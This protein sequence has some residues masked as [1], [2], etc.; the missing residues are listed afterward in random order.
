M[1]LG[2]SYIIIASIS[3]YD[4]YKSRIYLDFRFFFNDN[5]IKPVRNGKEVQIK[6]TRREMS[7]KTIRQKSI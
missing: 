2:Q 7:P 3:I 6:K 5:Y 1:T 4:A